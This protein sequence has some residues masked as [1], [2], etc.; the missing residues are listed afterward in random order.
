MIVSYNF[1]PIAIRTASGVTYTPDSATV[2]QNLM[3]ELWYA[4]AHRKESRLAR[5]HQA[6]D[7]VEL[8][9]EEQE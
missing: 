8:D 7:F 9:L 6:M 2:Y 5:L 3:R 1:P 4:K